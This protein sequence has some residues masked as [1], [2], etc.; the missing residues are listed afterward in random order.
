MGS[1]T[2]WDRVW[3]LFEGALDVPAADR[4]IWLQNAC[5][6]PTLLA[7]VEELLAAHVREAGVLDKSLSPL[8]TPPAAPTRHVP[9]RVD[10]YSILREIGR[11]GMGVVY[12]AEDLRLGRRVALKF[13]TSRLSADP[14]A[15]KRLLREARAASRLDHPNICAVYDVGEAEG[16][17]P[18]VAM[19]F[20]EGPT[21]EEKLSDGPLPVPE[22]VEVARQTAAGLEQAHRQGVIHRDVKPSNLLVEPGGVVRILDFGVAKLVGATATDSGVR[23]GTPVYMAPEQI[24]GQP[25]SPASDLWSLGVVLFQML[26]GRRPFSGV[27][28]MTAI[29]EILN[30][31]PPRLADF[32]DAPRHLQ[33]VIDR[34]L[35]KEPDARYPGADALLRDLALLRFD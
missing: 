30:E 29:Y 18:Y 9:P 33:T 34:L 19:A 1:D 15:R 13:L 6:D 35:M 8:P 27:N 11:G 31:E 12:L 20:Y 14:S 24:L 3:E 16:G 28:E 5:Q 26:A 4:G 17:R 32:V 22:A 21:V 25:V 23:L 7:E 2:Q 10:S